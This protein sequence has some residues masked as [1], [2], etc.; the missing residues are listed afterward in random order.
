[1]TV[2]RNFVK[3]VGLRVLAALSPGGGPLRKAYGGI[4]GGSGSGGGT[5]SGSVAG[6]LALVGQVVN[7]NNVPLQD[8]YT[9]AAYS[10]AAYCPDNWDGL[11]GNPVC[12]ADQATSSPDEN[13]LA[14]S[15]CAIYRGSETVAEITEEHDIAGNVV[16][17]DEKRLIVVS[18]RGTSRAWE[19]MR[20]VQATQVQAYDLC[21]ECW[22]HSGFNA[23]FRGV[24]PLV[25]G[26]VTACLRDK[27]G[28]RVV[29]TGHSYGGAV[30]TITGAWL[31]F[32][33]GIDADIFTYGAPRAGNSVFA[34]LVSRTA[35]ST[36][37]RRAAGRALVTARV[38]NR[39]D[40]VTV[41]PPMVWDYAHT[42][43]EYWFSSGFGDALAPGQQNLRKCEGVLHV[44]CSAAFSFWEMLGRLAERIKDHGGYHVLSAPCPA[45]EDGREGR[46]RRIEDILPP[47]KEVKKWH[48]G[49]KAEGRRRGA[50]LLVH[51][52]PPPLAPLLAP[53]S[54]IPRLRDGLHLY[55]G[56]PLC[57]L[58]AALERHDLFLLCRIRIELLT[59]G[60]LY[61]LVQLQII[62]R[63]ETQ[64]DTG[65]AGTGGTTDTVNVRLGVGGQ[66]VIEHH[67]HLGDIETTGGHVGGDQDVAGTGPEL[68][69]G[70]KASRLRE[71]AVKRDGAEAQRPQ[72]DSDTLR[73]EDDEI[74]VLADL[75]DE[76]VVLQE[77]R[78]GLVLVGA[79]ADLDGVP[80]TGALQALDLGA[81]GSR[82]QKGAALARD[83][84]EQLVD[85]GAK[86][87]VQQAIGLVHDQVLERPQGEALCLFEVVDEAARGGNDDVRLLAKGDGL[88]DHVE[89]AHDDSAPERYHGPEGFKGLSN[90]GRQLARRGQD[91]AEQRLRLVEK[92]LQHGQGKGG[93]LSAARLGEADDVAVLEG[94]GN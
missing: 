64:G 63:D 43:P 31:R 94:D 70:A 5:G 20:D 19:W 77:G 17:N 49:P 69:E 30:A 65:L 55:P 44:G 67:V 15:G 62:L 39:M 88:G 48:W 9:F 13:N 23:A 90:L 89:A 61:P 32:R 18:F 14:R 22:L 6:D 45:A 72:Q 84:L 79:D 11:L 21:S 82:E 93:R 59:H 54:V 34:E 68:V 73:L 27:P 74:C 71:L 42:T 46:K 7:I 85:A 38:T 29:V 60:C 91:E 26:N 86:V 58:D 2:L 33:H 47:L 35:A 92:R 53:P 78:D 3:V 81:H 56:V 12:H 76:D 10:H 57:F 16:V 52:V 28:Y 40:I 1:M 37:A 75:R 50:V 80:Q 87:H 24:E 51:I 66:I 41:Q 36:A 8:I 4:Y 25:T 83:E